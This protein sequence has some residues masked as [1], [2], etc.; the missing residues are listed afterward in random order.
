MPKNK[1]IQI[2]DFTDRQI[3]LAEKRYEEGDYIGA[4]NVA[5]SVAKKTKRYEA[6]RILAKVYMDIYLVRLAAEYWF[7]F[8][9]VCPARERP[10]AYNGLG[11]CFYLM[12]NQRLAA[13]YYDLQLSLATDTEYDYLDEKLDFFESVSEPYFP[14]FYISYPLEKIPSDKRIEL[15]ED[16]LYQK[17]KIPTVKYLKSIKKDDANYMGAQLRLSAHY[18]IKVKHETAKKLLNGLIGDF[19]DDPLPV[20]N[21]FVLLVGIGD[22]QEALKVYDQ[23]DK[24]DI[25]EFQACNKIAITCMEIAEYERAIFYSLRAL[26]EEPYSVSTLFLTGSAYYNLG[27]YDK[28]LQYFTY[29]YQ[30]TDYDVALYYLEKAKN[31]PKVTKPIGYRLKFPDDVRK[32]KIK[33]VF[34]YLENVPK[35]TT[36]N[37]PSVIQLC[38]WIYSFD[39]EL[40]GDF[41]EALL[42]TGNK[43][44]LDYF[45]NVLLVLEVDDRVKFRIVAK[46][47]SL[48]YKIKVNA[49]YNGMHVWFKLIPFAE[50][51][52]N[53]GFQESKKLFK[54]AYSIAFAKISAI[55]KQ[56]LKSLN[57]VAFSVYKRLKKIN[58][59]NM[60]KNAKVLAVCFIMCINNSY[61]YEDDYFALYFEVQKSEIHS[62]LE[63]IGEYEDS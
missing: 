32:K 23:L 46:L 62:L 41:A 19:P 20:I 11:A 14:E 56:S 29:V 10:E 17:S 45:L 3:E 38:D 61:K 48:G 8:L 55:Q 21:M 49:V 24:F 4:I 52:D 60:V 25:K 36:K 33:K 5:L 16:S 42:S 39:N 26:D 47:V 15:A 31:P 59:L 30:I 44:I 27:Q 13:Y 35:I 37:L 12:E 18:I 40:Q 22:K 28:A 7:R 57:D 34:D 50:F 51:D 43:T 6:Y 53:D 58:S 1:P 54:Q 2:S 63:L 9:S